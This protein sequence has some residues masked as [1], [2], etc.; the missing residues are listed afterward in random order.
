MKRIS[1]PHI[2]G[3]LLCGLLLGLPSL[4]TAQEDLGMRITGN[5]DANFG[6]TITNWINSQE[7]STLAPGLISEPI[8]PLDEWEMRMQITVERAASAPGAPIN[9]R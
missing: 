3:L 2:K 4:V 8:V 1:P 7:A 9:Q 5:D 6:L